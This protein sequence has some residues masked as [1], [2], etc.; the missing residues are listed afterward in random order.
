MACNTLPYKSQHCGRHTWYRTSVSDPI[1]STTSASVQPRQGQRGRAKTKGSTTPTTSA[2]AGASAPA[3][4]RWRRARALRQQAGV[5][6]R[7]AM[8]SDMAADPLS[9]AA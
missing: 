6:R 8:E 3:T 5:A 4:D 9:V 2:G 7:V 1:T